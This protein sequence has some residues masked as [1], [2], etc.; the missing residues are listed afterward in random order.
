MVNSLLTISIKVNVLVNGMS[1]RERQGTIDEVQE[2]TSD[3]GSVVVAFW[4][5]LGIRRRQRLIEFRPFRPVFSQILDD[6]RL[7]ADRLLAF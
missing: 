2:C 5:R 3:P 7:G 1:R 6:L 4:L